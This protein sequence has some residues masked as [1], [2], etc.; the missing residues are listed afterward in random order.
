MICQYCLG[1]VHFMMMVV[2]KSKMDPSL[3]LNIRLPS[4][5]HALYHEVSK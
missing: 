5:E 2:P 4:L 1:S 3:G